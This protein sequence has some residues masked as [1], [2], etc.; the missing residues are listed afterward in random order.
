M[1]PYE[2]T[3]VS[4]GKERHCHFS[5]CVRSFQAHLWSVLTAYIPV[6]GEA[7]PL[8]TCLSSDWAEKNGLECYSFDE[9][10]PLR[11][12]KYVQLLITAVFDFV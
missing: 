2:L 8:Q 5:M 3:K 1:D 4:F 12:I 6:S 10:T 9:S 7:K 11:L